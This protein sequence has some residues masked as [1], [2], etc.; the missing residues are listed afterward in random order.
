[1]K[2]KK[3]G[4]AVALFLLAIHTMVIGCN[5]AA[6]AKVV[7]M[8]TTATIITPTPTPIKDTSKTYLAL[9]DSYTIGQ[10][11]DSS[12][13]FPAQTVAWLSAYSTIKVKPIEYIATTGWTTSDL[14]AAI[15]SKNPQGPYDIVSLLI[16]VNDQYRGYDTSGYITRFTQLLQKSI[17]LAG[18]KPNHVFVVSIPDYSV[19]PFASG[20]NKAQISQQIDWFNAINKRIAFQY[21]CPYIYITDLTRQGATD[22]TLIAPDGL[23]P[24]GKEYEKWS[25]LL[26]AVIKATY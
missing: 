14:Q 23:H 4:F 5:K 7:A 17:Q 11:V 15:Q 25:E 6:T 1:M 12:Q 9:G 10:S 22:G 26:G 16:G 18:G 21:N 24:S 8:D 13:R 19:T 3:T 2:K 20:S